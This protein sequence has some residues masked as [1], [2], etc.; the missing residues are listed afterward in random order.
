[1]M[2]IWRSLSGRTLS[3][4]CRAGV[5]GVCQQQHP[6]PP[7]SSSGP[8]C[9]SLSSCSS[10]RS[11]SCSSSSSKVALMVAAAA[12]AAVGSL[13]SKQDLLQRPVQGP[14]SCILPLS[15]G[16]QAQQ[17]Q[18]QRGT[19]VPSL[20]RGTRALQTRRVRDPPSVSLCLLPSQPRFTAFR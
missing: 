6:L 2:R 19:L 7:S 10:S 3:S 17:Q 9:R 11:S 13:L 1:M 20:P 4:S 16:Q 15:A 14:P 12:T 18:G 8:V 5:G